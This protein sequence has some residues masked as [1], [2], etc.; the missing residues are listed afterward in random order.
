MASTTGAPQGANRA[1][2]GS[3]ETNSV[4]SKA[5]GS[6][7]STPNESKPLSSAITEP[8]A[9]AGKGTVTVVDKPIIVDGGVFDGLGQTFTASS[10]LG[11][12]G[13]SESQKPVFILRNGAT[14]R[15]VTIGANGA[16]G[17]HVYGGANLQNVHWQD[18]GED[19][20]T[21]KTAGDVNIIGGSASKATDKIF[22][23]N[24]DTNFTVKDFNA[25]HFSTLV[26]TNGGKEIKANVT[27]NGGQFSNGSTMFRTDST[28][29]KANFLGEIAISNVRTK[30]RIRDGLQSY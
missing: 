3:T 29:A 14:L 16:D 15:N 10:Q 7:S 9:V 26:R 2:T 22:Q 4:P 12:G 5:K 20:L 28:Q 11:D 1:S 24:A 8:S 19:A 25:D 18:V 17:I 27:I 6:T 23:L 21:V 30:I 13:Q